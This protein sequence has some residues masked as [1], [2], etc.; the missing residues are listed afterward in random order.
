MQTR[1]RRLWRKDRK[2]WIECRDQLRRSA[3]KVRNVVTN[4]FTRCCRLCA[5]F[6]WRKT[7]SSASS[8]CPTCSGVLA[9]GISRALTSGLHFSDHWDNLVLKSSNF[10]CRFSSDND[11]DC[12]PSSRIARLCSS[13][14]LGTAS[15][16][17]MIIDRDS[18]RFVGAPNSRRCIRI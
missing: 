11:P 7:L 10:A 12:L 2:G 9:S 15:D 8:A 14:S 4:P 3:L 6:R 13:A 1:N 17:L 5:S 16:S 18:P